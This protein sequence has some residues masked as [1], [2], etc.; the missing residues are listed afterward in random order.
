MSIILCYL[1]PAPC[2]EHLAC[3]SGKFMPS[4]GITNAYV[5]NSANLVFSTFAGCVLVANEISYALPCRLVSP[6]A[7]NGLKF[8]EGDATY[9]VCLPEWA[10][11]KPPPLLVAATA[12]LSSAD[13]INAD[14]NVVEVCIIF[15]YSGFS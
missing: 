10:R 15:F 8:A 3:C 5:S 1:L 11:P 4:S 9:C 13:A 2:C 7:V 6:V 12:A 14:A